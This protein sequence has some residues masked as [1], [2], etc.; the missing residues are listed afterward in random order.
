MFSSE[1][2]NRETNN[3]QRKIA[4]GKYPWLVEHRQLHAQECTDSIPSK[5]RIKTQWTIG[6]RFGSL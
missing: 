6:K 2:D 3:T 5:M 4:M 1:K